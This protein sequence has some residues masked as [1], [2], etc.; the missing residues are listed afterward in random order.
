MKNT[1]HAS[2]NEIFQKKILKQEE[3]KLHYRKKLIHIFILKIYSCLYLKIHL[4]QKHFQYVTKYDYLII[5][6]L[7]LSFI[8]YLIALKGCSSNIVME[9]VPE[10]VPLIPL[11]LFVIGFSAFQVDVV[12]I[13][14]IKRKISKVFIYIMLFQLFLILILFQGSSFQNHGIINK[15]IFFLFLFI[16]FIAIYVLDFIRNLFVKYSK[17]TVCIMFFLMILIFINIHSLMQNGK[18]DKWSQGFKETYMSNENGTCIIQ[19]P[20][21]CFQDLTANWF[22][23]SRIFNKNDC[24]KVDNTIPLYPYYEEVLAYPKTQFFTREQKFLE[25]FQKHIISQITPVKE[26]EI[27]SSDYEVFLNQINPENKK[28]IINVKKNLTL[29]ERSEKINNKI[30]KPVKNIL[31]IFIDSVSRQHFKRKLP[32]TYKWLE[33]FYNNKHSLFESYQ[34]FKY[35]ASGTHTLPNMMRA[36]Y[37]TDYSKVSK[38]RSLVKSFKDQ[39]FITAKSSN[40]CSAT[41]FDITENDDTFLGFDIESFDHENVA[42]SCDP[43]YRKTDLDDVHSYM[44]GSTA[45]VRRCLYGNDVHDYVLDYADKF[46]RVYEKN[47]KFL[48][49][50]LM[51][52]HEPSA[53]LLKYLDD[54]LYEFLRKWEVDGL[55]NDTAVVFYADHGHHLNIFYYLLGL[56]DLMY[57]LRLP[58]IFALLPR[59]LVFE[60]GEYLKSLENVLISS[61]DIYNFFSYLAGDNYRV[62]FGVSFEG[63]VEKVRSW[64]DIDLES[65]LNLCLNA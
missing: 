30:N 17:P 8:L 26:K 33:F 51:D 50:Y 65:S 12:L 43:N 52:G 48:E 29:V 54:P 7:L 38:A 6:N 35:H 9:C 46:W 41:Y 61:Y 11:G 60:K 56:K 21:F 19:P 57:E 62:P 4:I 13:L 44:V 47:S 42:F 16:E 23:L 53:E 18:C 14:V 22:D 3:Q 28:I 34:F 25:N 40:L 1:A 58:M 24:S 37:G 49:L 45:M 15:M 63:E 59:E 27:N 5:L 32:K 64:K 20:E 10:M 36:F 2:N 31:A 55:L 39:G